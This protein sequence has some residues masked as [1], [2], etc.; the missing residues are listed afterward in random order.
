M[1]DSAG[2]VAQQ[3]TGPSCDPVTQEPI[4]LFIGGFGV[5]PAEVLA[6]EREADVSQVKCSSELLSDCLTSH[7][8]IL[9]S[10][11]L[12]VRREAERCEARNASSGP[13][14]LAHAA[15]CDV[16]IVNTT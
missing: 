15:P 5:G 12:R 2:T 13:D 4:K 1:S 14:V 9:P 11:S 16:L 6:H 7:S 10:H 3:G 8:A